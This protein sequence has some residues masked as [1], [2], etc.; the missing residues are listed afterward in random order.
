MRTLPRPENGGQPASV[1]QGL[2]CSALE[3]KVTDSIP[4]CS[5]C[6]LV[7]VVCKNAC[8]LRF[9][10]TFKNP[11]GQNWSGAFHYGMP[12]NPRCSFEDT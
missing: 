1:T 2:L 4:G 9:R 7:G 12:H 8:A 10:V 11:R 6:I 3:H 5:S